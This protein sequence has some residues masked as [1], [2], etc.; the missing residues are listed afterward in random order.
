MSHSLQHFSLTPFSALSSFEYP[1]FSSTLVWIPQIL[2]NSQ[3]CCFTLQA[4][5]EFS[6]LPQPGIDTPCTLNSVSVASLQYNA[7]SFPA[8]SSEACWLASHLKAAEMNPCE[9]TWLCPHLPQKPLLL[10]ISVAS[11]SLQTRQMEFKAES[12]L[13][14]PWSGSTWSQNWNVVFVIQNDACLL[15]L[16]VARHVCVNTCNHY[17]L[18]FKF[19]SFFH[20]ERIEPAFQKSLNPCDS[21]SM[22]S[23][24]QSKFFLPHEQ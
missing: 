21:T 15:K 11:S 13:K 16:H 22:K 7:K 23:G 4:P 2:V 19:D 9:H 1:C 17:N 10:Q 20:F 6:Q 12:S 14:S 18:C 3:Q 8:V 5:C 24:S